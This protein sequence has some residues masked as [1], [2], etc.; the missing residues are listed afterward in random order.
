MIRRCDQKSVATILTILAMVTLGSSRADAETEKRRDGSDRWV[1]SLSVDL[2]F[3]FQEVE[4][5]VSSMQVPSGTPL[6]PFADNHK[7]QI[8]PMAGGRLEIMSPSIP[9]P[10][11]PRFFVDGEILSVSNQ[12]RRV[13][14]EGNPSGL[15][16]PDRDSFPN[17]VILGKGSLT[18]T[19]LKNVSYG[20]GIGIAFPV[21]VYDIR[22]LIKPMARYMRWKYVFEGVV[23]DSKRPS[24]FGPTQLIEL[25]G[26][27]SL[28]S[29]AIGPGLE[30]NFEAIEMNSFKASVFINFSA[31]KILGDRKV[32]FSTTAFDSQNVSQYQANWTAEVDPWI[33]RAGVGFRLSWMGL[34]SGWLGMGGD[35]QASG[36]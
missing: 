21:E 3:S 15:I 16:E 25:Y 19:D 9:I 30:L 14:R 34:G 6:R 12:K 36:N 33:Y 35:N 11:R 28:D 20:A 7:T 1:P 22:I 27:D 23:L 31:F 2:D 17:S 29:D 8:S 26:N 4:G 24:N 10:S 13:A 18:T 32:A 5:T